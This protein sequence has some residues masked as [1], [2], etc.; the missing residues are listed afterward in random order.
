M[1]TKAFF[2][3]TFKKF[4]AFFGAFY[5]FLSIL[6]TLGRCN[7]NLRNN[8]TKLTPYKQVI[9]SP[10]QKVIELYDWVLDTEINHKTAFLTPN[11]YHNSPFKLGEYTAINLNFSAEVHHIY[12]FKALLTLNTINIF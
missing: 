9:K 1:F 4:M 3:E 11:F 10:L 6:L 2:K 8:L 12:S 5:P 7:P